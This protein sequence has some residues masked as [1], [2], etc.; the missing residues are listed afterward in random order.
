VSISV[1][2]I[3]FFVGVGIAPVVR[4]LLIGKGDLT[5]RRSRERINRRIAGIRD[6]APEPQR[7]SVGA[8][9]M[10]AG[11]R[12]TMRRR[13]VHDASTVLVVMGVFVVVGSG[14]E[15]LRGPTGAVLDDVATPNAPA[16]S[17]AVLAEMAT[18]VAI[19]PTATGTTTPSQPPAPDPT[20]H[21]TPAPPTPTPRQTPPRPRA[22]SDRM[23][24]L[25]PCPERR[26]CYVYVVRRGDNLMSIAN[27]FGIPYDEV[28]A[29]NPQIT[30]PSRVHAGDR[31]AL[32]HPR[33]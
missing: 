33:R 32:P 17:V 19:G 22:T 14:F 8:V 18:P 28:L 20:L 29:R 4:L 6:P 16:P 30:D 25:T 2:V 3:G 27:W 13:L 21:P 1:L 9:G 5:D 11:I 31:I 7:T 10:G 23:A 26:D 24:V 15:G 12:P